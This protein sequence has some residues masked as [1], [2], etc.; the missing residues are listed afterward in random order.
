MSLRRVSL[1]NAIISAVWCDGIYHHPI[2]ANL[3]LDSCKHDYQIYGRHLYIKAVWSHPHHIKFF[4]SFVLYAAA[5]FC[6]LQG[7]YPTA[8][9]VIV[10]FTRSCAE[11][12]VRYSDMPTPNLCVEGQL[13]TPHPS[14][15]RHC[16]ETTTSPDD[17]HASS[18]VLDTLN[19][20]EILLFSP[21]VSGTLGKNQGKQGKQ[22][23]SQTKLIHIIAYMQFV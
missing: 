15:P 13:P 18:T 4:F 8:L 20:S 19:E 5:E 21:L 7:I 2:L 23:A 12:M 17:Y 14:T 16:F 9:V 10:A 1:G 6:D 11:R 22:G 3:D